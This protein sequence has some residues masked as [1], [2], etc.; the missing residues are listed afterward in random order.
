MHRSYL[1]CSLLL[2]WKKKKNLADE[3]VAAVA[4]VAAA[5]GAAAGRNFDLMREQFF[6]WVE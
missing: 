6:S 2:H 5:V 1:I 3:E 4:A